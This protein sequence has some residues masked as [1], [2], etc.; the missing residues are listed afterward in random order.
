MPTG[1]TATN[2]HRS[3][4]HCLQKRVWYKQHVAPLRVDEIIRCLLCNGNYFNVDGILPRDDA[5]D[6]VKDGDGDPDAIDTATV[7]AVF[8]IW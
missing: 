2:N 1:R 7:S 6:A 4:S 3:N 5:G 8:A